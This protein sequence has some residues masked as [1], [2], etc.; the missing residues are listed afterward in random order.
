MTALAAR[1]D[2]DV[3]LELV[4]GSDGPALAVGLVGTLKVRVRARTQGRTV[5]RDTP[6]GVAFLEAPDC[7]WWMW[8]R[9]RTP[10]DA[11]RDA[12]QI[13]AARH[14]DPLPGGLGRWWS[15]ARRSRLRVVLD[16]RSDEAVTSSPL[17]H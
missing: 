15:L 3:V 1:A 12:E 17:V 11:D 5:E 14:G 8:Q 4:G 13:L 6:V 16:A 10:E 7:D 2:V 9:F